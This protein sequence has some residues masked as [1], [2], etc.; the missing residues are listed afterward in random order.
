MIPVLTGFY[1]I[2]NCFVLLNHKTI[3]MEINKNYSLDQIKSDGLIEK[4]VKDLNSK[5]FV[6]GNKVYFFEKMNEDILRLYSVINKQSF[7]L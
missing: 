2:C 1:Q 6:N 3:D 4:E 5:I 7:F